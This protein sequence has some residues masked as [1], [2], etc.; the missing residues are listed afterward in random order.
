M[1]K[2]LVDQ[3]DKTRLEK[4][5]IQLKKLLNV[6]NVSQAEFAKRLGVNKNTV[7]SWVN[8]K[9]EPT[10]LSL[11]KIFDFF[12]EEVP[13]ELFFSEYYEK[14]SNVKNII[15]TC[16]ERLNSQKRKFQKEIRRLRKKLGY[17][18]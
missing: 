2:K 11:I 3:T 12:R 15:N 18:D 13:L 9:S 1:P 8:G 7:L 4:F 14:K 17:D 5:G 16:D 6:K 10:Y